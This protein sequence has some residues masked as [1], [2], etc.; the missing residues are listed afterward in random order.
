[1]IEISYEEVSTALNRLPLKDIDH[2][3]AIARGGLIPAS[4]VAYNLNVSLSTIHINYRDDSNSPRFDRPKLLAPIEI[5]SKFRN[6]LL[7]DDVVVSGKTMLAAKKELGDFNVR[8][9]A[10]LGQADYIVFPEI[11]NCVKWPWKVR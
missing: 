7:V 2:V 11:K 1:M 4:I 6:I 8:T 3:V 5:S 9:M 10:M